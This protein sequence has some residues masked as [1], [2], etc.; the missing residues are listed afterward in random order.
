MIKILPINIF[1][2]IYTHAILG[3]IVNETN[4]TSIILFLF[5]GSVTLALPVYYI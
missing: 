4:Y 5:P 2:I 1:I 3:V